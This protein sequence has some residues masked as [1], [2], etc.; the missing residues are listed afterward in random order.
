MTDIDDTK[1]D[2]AALIPAQATRARSPRRGRRPSSSTA[3]ETALPTPFSL[4]VLVNEVLRTSSSVDVDVLATEVERRVSKELGVKIPPRLLP[5]FHEAL[6]VV[7][8]SAISL[9]RGKPWGVGSGDQ[10]EGDVQATPVTGADEFVS[11]SSRGAKVA[12]FR[13]RYESYMRKRISVGNG[14]LKFRADC[15]I[16][17]L[18]H[19]CQIKRNHIRA[20]MVTLAREERDIELMHEY[21]VETLGEV[22]REAFYDLWAGAA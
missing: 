15:T 12:Y 13:D 7:I 1:I 18:E 2:V 6:V 9:Q 8:R 14:E 21:E 16:T 4:R 5:V 17:D 20:T 19:S 11:S 10:S 3:G 22:P